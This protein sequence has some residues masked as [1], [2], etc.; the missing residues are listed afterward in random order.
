[1]TVGSASRLA[2]RDSLPIG[3]HNFQHPVTQVTLPPITFLL[4]MEAKLKALKVVD[5]KQILAS[6][7]VSTTTKATKGDLI[8]KILA[9]KDALDAYAKQYPQ[10]DLLAPPEECVV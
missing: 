4:I 9:S 8:V 2:R 10:D 6:A 7:K 5:L 3:S 1:M